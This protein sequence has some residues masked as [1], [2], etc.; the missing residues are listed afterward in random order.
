M[1]FL[2]DKFKINFAYKSVKIINI[3]Y[4][5]YY[6]QNFYRNYSCNTYYIGVI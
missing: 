2:I 5:L 6:N 1:M 4:K 3:T